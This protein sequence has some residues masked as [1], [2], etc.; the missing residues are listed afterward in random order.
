MNDYPFQPGSS[1]SEWAFIAILVAVLFMLFRGIRVAST[2]TPALLTPRLLTTALVVLVWLG[3]FYAVVRSG[4]IAAQPMPRLVLL[5]VSV[6]IVSI[7]I[8]LSAIGRWLASGLSLGTLVAFHG[9]RLP[10]EIVLHSWA[11]QGTIPATMTWNGSNFDIITGVLAFLIAP[12]AT[13]FRGL[14]WGFNLIGLGLLINVIRVAVLSSPLPFA[15]P[16]DNPLL[17][18]L[19]LPYALIAP[20]CVGGAL[21][22]HIVLFRALLQNPRTM[23]G[24]PLSLGEL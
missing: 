3:I 5:F 13:R 21:I 6:N 16:L 23:P 12:F 15:W 18:G 17:L 11:Q 19:H 24:G 1:L 4:A 14:A 20:I 9:F 10:L 8:G 2:G 22:G 7:V